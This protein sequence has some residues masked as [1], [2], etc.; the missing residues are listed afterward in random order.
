MAKEKL[1]SVKEVANKLTA[2]ESTIRNHCADGTFPNAYKVF[3]PR[4]DYWL[5]PESD[6]NGVEI[7]MGRPK[8]GDK[9]I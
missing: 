5:I 8:K 6:L 9:N 2:A 3:H 1:L 7:K 4:G